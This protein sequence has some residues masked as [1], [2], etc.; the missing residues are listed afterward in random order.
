VDFLNSSHRTVSG[1]GEG[2]D[3]GGEGICG[4]NERGRGKKGHAEIYS[5]V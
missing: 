5:T 2:R 1:G 4:E 3:G